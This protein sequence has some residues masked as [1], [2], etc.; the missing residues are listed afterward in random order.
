MARGYVIRLEHFQKHLPNFTRIEP[1]VSKV[2]NAF[3]TVV[4]WR[5]AIW[6]GENGPEMDLQTEEDG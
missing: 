4:H 5:F 2:K 3:C 1:G 6:Y